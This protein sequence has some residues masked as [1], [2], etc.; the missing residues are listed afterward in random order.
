MKTRSRLVAPSGASGSAAAADQP[1]HGETQDSREGYVLQHREVHSDLRW[2]AAETG[3]A[4]GPTRVELV[5]SS[6][7]GTRSN[8]LSYEPFASRSH[9]G[10]A[11]AGRGN[12]AC[13]GT[14][15]RWLPAGAALHPL[16]FAVQSIVLYHGVPPCQAAKTRNSLSA[17]FCGRESASRRK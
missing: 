10:P 5:T 17:G 7:S 2:L 12:P 4:L 3:D 11:K 16:R 8:Q 13:H 9:T 14:S 6:L 15:A 1:P